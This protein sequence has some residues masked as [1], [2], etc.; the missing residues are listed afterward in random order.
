MNA[1]VLHIVGQ[2]DATTSYAL[3]NRTFD[4][5][6]GLLQVSI[7]TL[8]TRLR[9]VFHRRPPTATAG[10]HMADPSRRADAW[11]EIL[12]SERSIPQHPSVP[13]KSLGIE[14]SGRLF[15]NPARLCLGSRASIMYR[16]SSTVVVTASAA[17]GRDAD[18]LR[19]C[20]HHPPL[21]QCASHEV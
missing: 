7:R 3:W 20:T 18:Q 17:S 19:A 11:G 16:W 1:E 8:L 14:S 12:D 15:H 21:R 13:T 10:R 4:S 5:D 9:R 6:V 2:P